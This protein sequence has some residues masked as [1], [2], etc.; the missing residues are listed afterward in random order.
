MNE[1]NLNQIPSS[2]QKTSSFLRALIIAI[3]LILITVLGFN[4]LMPVL[5][6]ALVI[7]FAAWSAIIATIMFFCIAALLFF[8]VPS[9]LIVLI[10]LVA[11]FWVVVAII[12]FPILFPIVIPIFIILL[13]I[14]YARRRK[15]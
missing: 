15:A 5:G 12:F 13:F 11:L 10:S 8:I 7:S 2:P 6:I 14:G 9:V 1:K 3:A 4:L